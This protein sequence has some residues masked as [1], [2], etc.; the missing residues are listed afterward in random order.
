MTAL[1]LR[2]GIPTHVNGTT[3][4]PTAVEHWPWAGGIAN[5][6]WFQ[7]LG[8][9]PIVLSFSAADATA[10]RGISVAAGADYLIPA[11]IDSFF[12]KSVAA[13]AFQAVAFIR[14]G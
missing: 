11:E 9:G 3:V 12:T 6:L 10:A 4:N 8:T 13:E 2:G 1:Y 14:R 5:Y 7:N